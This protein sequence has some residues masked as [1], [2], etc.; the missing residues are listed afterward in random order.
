MDGF[1]VCTYGT[2][3]LM[4]LCLIHEINKLWFV[5]KNVSV[6]ALESNIYV[7]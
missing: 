6:E 7:F 3:V 5:G 4:L 1:F 2:W